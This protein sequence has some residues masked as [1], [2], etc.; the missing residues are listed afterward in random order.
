MVENAD[1][2]HRA[3]LSEIPDCLLCADKLRLQQV[4]DNLFANSYKYAGTA[5]QATVYR[6]RDFLAIEIEDSG[7]G[8]GEEEL[9][10][11]K[12]K[13]KRGKNAEGVEGAGLGL[14]ISDYFIKEMKG[15]LLLENTKEKTEPFS[16]RGLKVTV[17]LPLSGT[18]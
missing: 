3:S 15:E 7:G 9:P 2:L 16:S 1:Y 6:N 17:L 12:Q 10:L 18:V 14:Y 13:F 5:I 4:L 11:L 8:V